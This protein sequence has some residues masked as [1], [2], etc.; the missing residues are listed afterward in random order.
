MQ[1]FAYIAASDEGSA[2]QAAAA[3]G[4]RFMAGGTTL[5]D[6][7]KLEVERPSTVVDINAVPL[8]RIEELPGGGVRV[9]A[10]VAAAAAL[11]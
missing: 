11:P 4:A 3:P 5:V 8:T 1:P 2:R 7:M 10:M 9:G 6:L